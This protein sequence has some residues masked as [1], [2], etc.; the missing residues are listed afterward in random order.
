MN[1][2]SYLSKQVDVFTSAKTPPST[3]TQERKSFLGGHGRKRNVSVSISLEP[4]QEVST[5]SKT[6]LFSPSSAMKRSYSSP[7]DLI[8]LAQ[9]ASR[10]STPPITSLK[11]EVHPESGL[12]ALVRRMFFVRVMVMAWNTLRAALASLLELA[13]IRQR[14]IETGSVAAE[15]DEEASDEAPSPSSAI[16]LKAPPHLHRPHT[17]PTLE[18]SEDPSTSISPR[19]ISPQSSHHSDPPSAETTRSSTP[20]QAATNLPFHLQKTL[21][22]DLDET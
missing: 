16:L 14:R 15:S 7:A 8:T 5:W 22:L 18:P 20:V 1:S 17:A 6:F 13:S 21:V 2:L 4:K 19:S 10:R 12:K 3:P 9:E 11:P